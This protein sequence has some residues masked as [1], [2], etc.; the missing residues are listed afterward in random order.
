MGAPFVFGVASSGSSHLSRFVFRISPPES[1]YRDRS[2]LLDR[3]G[4]FLWREIADWEVPR[5]SARFSKI[6]KESPAK[7][8]N[9]QIASYWRGQIESGAGQKVCLKLF[10]KSNNWTADWQ[11]K[12]AP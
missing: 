12:D 7:I 11:A 4:L 8:R 9:K 10:N 3:P 6:F 5:A 1:L 2:E